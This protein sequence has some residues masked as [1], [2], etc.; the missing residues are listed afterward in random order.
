MQDLNE[1]N[2]DA[3]EVMIDRFGLEA[4]LETVADIARDKSDHIESNWQDHNLARSWNRIANRIDR[5]AAAAAR[6]V[7]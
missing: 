3:I 1:P 4:V 5:T 6:E 2:A 7:A